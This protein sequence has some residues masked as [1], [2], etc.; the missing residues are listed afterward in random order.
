M[1]SNQLHEALSA[2]KLTYREVSVIKLVIFIHI[3][4]A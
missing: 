1:S 4:P 3:V 2:V